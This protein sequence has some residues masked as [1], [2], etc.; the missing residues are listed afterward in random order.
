ME[1]GALG[2]DE[3]ISLARESL[4]ARIVK[5]PS[6][7]PRLQLLGPSCRVLLDAALTNDDDTST[8]FFD[9]ESVTHFEARRLAGWPRPL[10]VVIVG[11]P[12]GSTAQ[13]E[14]SLF[15][16]V[17]GRWAMLL[18]PVLTVTEGGSYVGDLGG[19][20]GPG[21]AYWGRDR[22]GEAHIEPA[23]YWL[24]RLRWN[25]R[26]FVRLPT[27]KSKG[28]YTDPVAALRELGVGYIDISLRFADFAQLR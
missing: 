23:R 1:P 12:G 9:R 6:A 19:D 2:Q 10:V 22:E 4:E 20:L 26:L 11:T 17:G 8:L 27:L 3:S 7:R 21:V 5:R 14:T 13:F 18:P 16:Q 15:A 28:R 25:G 24:R